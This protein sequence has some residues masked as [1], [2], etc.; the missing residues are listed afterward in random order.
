MIAYN[1]NY[2][3]NSLFDAVIAFTFSVDYYPSTEKGYKVTIIRPESN[4]NFILIQ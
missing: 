2:L 3:L 4:K 1:I